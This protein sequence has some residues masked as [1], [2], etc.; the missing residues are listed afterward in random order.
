[1]QLVA[2]DILV[3]ARGLSESVCTVGVLLGI[4]VGVT[5][6]WAR[7]FW[8]VLGA[9]LAG[10]LTGLLYGTSYDVQPLVAALALALAFGLGALLLIRFIVYVGVAF[11]CLFVMHHY[12]PRYDYPALSL[13]VGGVFG[14][15]LYRFW[16][17]ALTGALGALLT[18]YAGLCLLDGLHHLD[19]IDWANTNGATLNWAC[20]GTA[21][22]FVLVQ[23]LIDQARRGRSAGERNKT[24]NTEKTSGSGG[25][26]KA[27]I[28]A[29]GWFSKG[30]ER[31]RKAG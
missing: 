5:G 27:I 2:P 4:L 16:I 19:M 23:F 1:M 25:G 6:W 8:V 15:Y 24:S 9:T 10:G 30:W 18:V 3:E 13:L 22:G 28:D 26:S 14:L 31:L 11:T 7:R 12:F 17:M 20:I 29:R 21:A